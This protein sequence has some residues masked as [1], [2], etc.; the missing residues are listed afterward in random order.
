M[1][2]TTN[3]GYQDNGVGRAVAARVFHRGFPRARLLLRQGRTRVY[4]VRSGSPVL[5]GVR[6]GRVRYLAVYDRRA[7]SSRAKLRRTLRRAGR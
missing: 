3:A 1:V 2:L 4:A 5:V 7:I 6:R